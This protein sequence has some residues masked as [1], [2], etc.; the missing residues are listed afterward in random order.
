MHIFSFVMAGIGLVCLW[1]QSCFFVGYSTDKNQD[2][3]LVEGVP[4]GESGAYSANA[5]SFFF[6]RKETKRHLISK[7][8]Q[9]Y[10]FSRP[11]FVLP[12][13]LLFRWI[14]WLRA[15]RLVVPYM[16]PAVRFWLMLASA[17]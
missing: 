16:F 9:F 3:F 4:L 6:G 5:L 8:F 1:G 15:D 13:S 7:G 12:N 10:F 17:S 2:Y 14:A 11:F